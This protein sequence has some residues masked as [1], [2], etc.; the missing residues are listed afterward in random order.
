MPWNRLNKDHCIG[1][2]FRRGR[3]ETRIK[4]N[5]VVYWIGHFKDKEV[6]G[7]IYDVACTL[8]YGHGRK[9]HN[10]DGKPPEGITTTDILRMLVDC[11]FPRDVLSCRI[12]AL[13]RNQRTTG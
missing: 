5:N 7:R 8:I 6:A 4:Y 2:T 12:A 1:A 9:G 13:V 3:W 11:G 10:Y